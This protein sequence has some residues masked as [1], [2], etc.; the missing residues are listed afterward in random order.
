MSS[1]RFAVAAH[2]LAVLAGREGASS[3]VIAA[4][5]CTNPVIV[6]RVMGALVEAGLVSAH[7]GRGGGYRLARSA[8]RISLRDV[9]EAVEP[10]GPLAPSACEPSA[11]CPIGAGMREAFEDVSARARARMA[12][13]LAEV[14]VSSLRD[15]AVS[16]GRTHARRGRTDV[17][18]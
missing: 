13:A 17:T 2:A 4:S 5:V 16:L 7:E 14:S 6:R 11:R 18:A 1:G 10:S 15:R 8:D 9:Y 12:E 3:D